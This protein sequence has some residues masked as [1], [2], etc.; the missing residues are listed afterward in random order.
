MSRTAGMKKRKGFLPKGENAW[1]LGL[2]VL[3]GKNGG[4]EG[5][6]HTR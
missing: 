3:N 1:T 6:Q 5:A 4:R 2:V